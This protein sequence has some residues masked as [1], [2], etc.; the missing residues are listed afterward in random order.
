MVSEL[1]KLGFTETDQFSHFPYFGVV[2][3]AIKLAGDDDYSNLFIAIKGKNLYEMFLSVNKDDI[4]LLEIDL[5]PISIKEL[6]LLKQENK[7]F[8]YLDKYC[9]LR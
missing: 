5:V 9:T 6:S 7:L 8:T 2:M 3:A 1:T 4:E